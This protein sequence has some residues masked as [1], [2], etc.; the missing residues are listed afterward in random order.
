VPGGQQLLGVVTT[1]GR[2]GF[3]VTLNACLAVAPTP[4][5]TCAV[6]VVFWTVVGVPVTHVEWTPKKLAIDRPLGSWPATTLHLNGVGPVP[7]LELMHPSKN[8]PTLA[9]P[10]S[11][12]PFVH[13]RPA[14]PITSCA[15][16]GGA[17]VNEVD[18]VVLLRDAVTWTSVDWLTWLVPIA[19]LALEEPAGTTT[20]AGMLTTPGASLL[21]ATVVLFAVVALNPTAPVAPLPPVT[22]DGVT[23]TL[24]TVTGPGGGGGAGGGGEG[25]QPESVA[26]A[27]VC[28]SLTVTLQVGELKG[29]VSIR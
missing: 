17:T 20:L 29:D 15:V 2:G 6:N 19:K 25:V 23:V 24:V 3:T 4:S 21:S 18:A 9:G 22:V 16:F 13:V 14:V 5:W 8:V 26:V 10:S 12:T 28:P 1:S 27:D 7:P 11:Q